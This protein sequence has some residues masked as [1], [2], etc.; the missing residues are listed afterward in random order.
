MKE[1]LSLLDTQRID[2]LN[3]FLFPVLTAAVPRALAAHLLLQRS[4]HGL[5]A[6]SDSFA[7]SI[8]LRNVIRLGSRLLVDFLV[9]EG[10]HLRLLGLAQKPRALVEAFVY[11]ADL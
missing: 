3:Q 7:E 4:I 10:H 1:L 8:F 2:R 9:R 6:D 11:L 5:F